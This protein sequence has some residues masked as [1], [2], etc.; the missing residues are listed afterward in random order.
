MRANESSP[1]SDQN[2]RGWKMEGGRWHLILPRPAKIVGACNHF[3]EHCADALPGGIH[4]LEFCRGNVAAI[5]A[6]IEPLLS[7]SRLTESFVN[8]IDEHGAVSASRPSFG[9]HRFYRARGSAD[10]VSERK[11]FLARE[12]AAAQKNL[13]RFLP[14]QFINVQIS[15]TSD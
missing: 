14:R 10:L 3:V 11:S 15:K 9:N 5:K 6:I 8:F 7:F 4:L 13:L 1:A 2:K 12:V